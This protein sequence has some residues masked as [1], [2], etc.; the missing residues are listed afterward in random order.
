M[1]WVVICLTF[2]QALLLPNLTSL[3]PFSGCMNNLGRV[4]TVIYSSLSVLLLLVLLIC[5]ATSYRC[6]IVRMMC[7]LVMRQCSPQLDT[8]AARIVLFIPSVFLVVHIFF[9]TDNLHGWGLDLINTY[10]VYYKCSTLIW[11]FDSVPYVEIIVLNHIFR[12]YFPRV[13]ILE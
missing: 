4:Y 12:I 2:G 10:S 11:I 3:F 1:S 7:V 6:V 8:S 5:Y 9:D 13:L